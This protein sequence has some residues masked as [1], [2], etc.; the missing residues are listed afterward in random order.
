MVDALKDPY[1]DYLTPEELEALRERNDGAY[2]GVGLQVAQRDGAVVVT[3]VFPDSPAREGRGARRATG[4]SRSTGS[5]RPARTW[6]PSSASI[7][8]EEG[9]T[10]R[11]GL[12]TGDGRAA[13]ARAEAL[14]HQGA[15]R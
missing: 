2:Y 13:G 14:A 12:R 10:V 6:R 4:S 7:R 5:R 11:V 8:G 1:T 3:R 9:T 15:R